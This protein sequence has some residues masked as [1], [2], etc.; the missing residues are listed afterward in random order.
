MGVM[1]SARWCSPRIRGGIAHNP[2]ASDDYRLGSNPTHYRGSGTVT[3]YAADFECDSSEYLSITDGA[4]SGL[5]P[6][7]DFSFVGWFNTESMNGIY[8]YLLSKL[9]NAGQYQYDMWRQNN[10]LMYWRVSHDGTNLTT[11]IATTAGALSHDTWYFFHVYHDNGTEIGISIHGAA[12]AGYDTAAQVN[13]IHDGTDPFH[14]GAFN[15]T[16]YEWDGKI[17]YVGLYSSVISAADALAL[18]SSGP[19][20]LHANLTAAQKTNLV[21][22]WD[23]EEESGARVDSHG[24]NDLTDNNTVGRAV[25]VYP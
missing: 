4:Q 16:T 17:A 23:F 11:V 25:V 5:D 24:S 15:A 19:T 6:V 22:W 20:L 18:Y 21:S 10:N 9:Q 7:A 8:M 3:T 2:L 12:G 14:I 1:D 13:G